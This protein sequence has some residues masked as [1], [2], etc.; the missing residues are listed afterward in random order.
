MP[1]H[2]K[3]TKAMVAELR[4]A[5]AND[6]YTEDILCESGQFYIEKNLPN[7]SEDDQRKAIDAYRNGFI[8]GA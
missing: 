7:L 5:G 1:K 8:K 6:T 4:E 2:K 3:L